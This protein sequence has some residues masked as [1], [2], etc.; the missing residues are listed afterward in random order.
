[1][2]VATVTV[3]TVAGIAGVLAFETPSSSAVGVAISV[4]TIPAAAYIGA[5]AAL[6]DGSGA[7][8]ALGVLLVNVVMVVLAGTLTL[9]VQRDARLI[10]A[11]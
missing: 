10:W 6:D 8:G 9:L 3:A 1:M 2:N 4:A 11:A 7:R 5:A